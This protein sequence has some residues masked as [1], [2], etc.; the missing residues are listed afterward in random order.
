MKAFRIMA[1]GSDCAVC[2]WVRQFAALLA[3]AVVLA[4]ALPGAAHDG[5][6]PVGAAGSLS[7]ESASTPVSM[8]CGTIDDS[9]DCGCVGLGGCHV[10]M[11]LGTAQPFDPEPRSHGAHA[12]EPRFDGCDIAP[13]I[14]PPRVAIA[15]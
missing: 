3:V 4:F 10:A 2:R 14:H 7:L 5:L 11:A 15:G 12:R 1:T 8:P 9:D 6:D 13:P